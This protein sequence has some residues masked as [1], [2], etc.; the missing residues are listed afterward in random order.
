[1][2][3]III[4]LT[5]NPLWKPLQS[6]DVMLCKNQGSLGEQVQPSKSEE[7]SSTGEVR[8]LAFSADRATHYL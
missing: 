1:M 3:D 5:Q 7:R 4:N 8:E 2:I 6:A